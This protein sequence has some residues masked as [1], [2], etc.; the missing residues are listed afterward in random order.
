MAEYMKRIGLPAIALTAITLFVAACTREDMTDGASG[1][2]KGAIGFQVAVSNN[3]NNISPARGYAPGNQTPSTKGEYAGS[4]EMDGGHKPIYLHAE[5]TD[6]PEETDRQNPMTRSTVVSSSENMYDKIKVSAYYYNGAW[7]ETRSLSAPNYFSDLTAARSGDRYDLSPAQHWPVNG[8]V[9][10][11][12]YAPAGDPAYAYRP[13]TDGSGEKRGPNIH[14]RVP[15]N[16]KDQKDL[17]IA[18]TNQTDCSSGRG[19]AVNL[20]FKHAMTCVRFS[21]GSDMIN[22]VIKRV[23]IKNVRCEG[24]FIYDMKDADQYTGADFALQ[25][26]SPHFNLEEKTGDF[27]QTLEHTIKQ[28]DNHYIITSDASFIMLPQQLEEGAEVQI[29]LQQ[30]DDQGNTI[31]DEEMIFG[32][33]GGKEWPAGKI[34]TYRISYDNMWQQLSIT[35]LDSFS[36]QGGEQSFRITSFDISKDDHQKRPASWVADFKEIRTVNGTEIENPEYTATPPAWLTLGQTESE[37][38]MVPREIKVTVARSEPSRTIDLDEKL[39]SNTAYSA[40]TREAPYNLAHSSGYYANNTGCIQN[41]ANCYVIDGPGWYILPLVYGN[42]ITNG[43]DNTTAYRPNAG[44]GSGVLNNFVNHLGNEIA[45]PY[46]LK[47][48]GCGNPIG[49]RMIWQDASSLISNDVLLDKEAYGGIGG[50]IFHISDTDIRQANA[51]IGLMATAP[52]AA[53][54]TSGDITKDIYV[55]Q[56]MWSWHIW[57]TPLLSGV[58]DEL[59]KTVTVTNHAGLRYDLMGVNLGWCSYDPVKIYDKRKCKVRF[60][61]TTQSGK[62]KTAEIVVIQQSQANYWHGYNT[63]YQWGRKDPFQP[64][65][66]DYNS[67][68][69][70]DY[71]NWANNNAH[72][73]SEDLSTGKEGLK[74]RIL[75]PDFFHRVPEILLPSGIPE[76]YDESF[77]NLWDATNT[78]SSWADEGASVR[79]TTIKTVY[80]PCPPGFKVPPVDAFTGFTKNGFNVILVDRPK[81]WN[82]ITE[83]Y[84]YLCNDVTLFN[85]PNIFIFY[86]D[87][88]KEG[89]IAMPTMG[90]RDWRTGSYAGV[91]YSGSPTLMGSDGLYWTAGA[92]DSNRGYYLNMMKGRSGQPFVSPLDSY[93]HVDGCCIR[94][95]KE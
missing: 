77:Y 82:G 87:E 4:F 53:D 34:V 27:T 46:I 21:C 61:A 11:L 7:D 68:D 89:H 30:I 33:I 17:L 9:R 35:D 79:N 72:P 2:D 38:D 91:S 29:V 16:V 44:S 49:A 88:T 84:T 22:C 69:W 42:A 28:E 24:D 71:R 85:T 95:C 45:S 81:N 51:T 37:G 76:G 1:S 18:Y 93:L 25:T 58:D 40:T 26:G 19:K 92:K 36:P 59:K 80:D 66:K 78:A 3:W 48:T 90:Y 86:T 57:V 8:N 14:I 67:K 41:T 60:T 47:N 10:F 6:Y 94:P 55:G 32:Y 50:I 64:A 56:A 62:T 70:F 65:S 5:I 54:G 12:A 52:Y 83:E 39:R 73:K 63:Y 74:K 31:D 20:N 23:T 13:S 75:Y 15:E 43:R